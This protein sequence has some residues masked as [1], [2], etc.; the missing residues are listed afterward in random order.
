MSIV[1]ETSAGARIEE[2]RLDLSADSA[3]KAIRRL[4]G[5]RTTLCTLERGGDQLFIA[6]GDGRYTVSAMLSDGTVENLVGDPQAIGTEPM[7]SGG[8]LI[9]QP[10]K[11]IVSA[12]KAIAVAQ[13]FAEARNWRRSRTWDR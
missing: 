1:V 13:D 9:D 6:G 10:A 2:E 12:E 8:Q 3:V 5:K 7:V 11:Y 4:D